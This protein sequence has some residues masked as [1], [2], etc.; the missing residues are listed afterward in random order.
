MT[1]WDHPDG[2]ADYV[3]AGRGAPEPYTGEPTWLPGQLDL[4]DALDDDTTDQHPRKD[5]TP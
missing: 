4:L 5:T 1:T 2:P 3:E